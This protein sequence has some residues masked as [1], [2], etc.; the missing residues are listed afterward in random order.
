MAA[1]E[2]PALFSEADKTSD[3]VFIV[4]DKKIHFTKAFLVASSDVFDRMF[5]GQFAEKTAQEIPLPDMKHW[6]VVEFL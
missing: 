3:V 2:E 4:E 1:K 5:N 6:E